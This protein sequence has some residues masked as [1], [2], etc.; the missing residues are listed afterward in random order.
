MSII[1]NLVIK[2]KAKI[3]ENKVIDLCGCVCYCPNCNDILND[4]ADCDDGEF[5]NYRCNS[6]DCT[7]IWH[8][9]MAPCPILIG[10]SP[11]LGAVN[12]SNYN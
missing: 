7:S 6:C 5:I 10:V 3:R 1:K 12:S 8:F 11:I 2:W 4:Q 9:D